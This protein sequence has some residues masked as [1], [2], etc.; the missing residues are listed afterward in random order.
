MGFRRV[1]RNENGM[2]V[3]RINDTGR[4]TSTISYGMGGVSVDPIMYGGFR[5]PELPPEPVDPP[6]VD[7]IAYG[8][9]EGPVPATAPSLT[10]GYIGDPSE[11]EDLIRTAGPY[12]APTPE[13]TQMTTGSNVDNQLI[14]PGVSMVKAIDQPEDGDGQPDP[15]E[16]GESAYWTDSTTGISYQFKKERVDRKWRPDTDKI[17][18]D[19]EEGQQAYDNRKP[20]FL[21]LGTYTAKERIALEKELEAGESSYSIRFSDLEKIK[22]QISDLYNPGGRSFNKSD[23]HKWLYGGYTFGPTGSPEEAI[24]IILDNMPGVLS[25]FDKNNK[26]DLEKWLTAKNNAVGILATLVE[27]TPGHSYSHSISKEQILS[28]L[29]AGQSDDPW[30][31]LD[32]TYKLSPFWTERGVSTSVPGTDYAEDARSDSDFT[33]GSYSSVPWSPIY[34]DFLNDK[35]GAAGSPA[36]FKYHSDQG[37]SNDPLQR[38]AYTQFLTQATED[39]PWGGKLE[40][41]HVIGKEPQ[42]GIVFGPQSNIYDQNR[43]NNFLQT[44]VPLTGDSLTGRIGEIIDVVK[45]VD[46]DYPGGTWDRYDPV[47][48]DQDYSSEQL[49]AYRWRHSFFEGPGSVVNQ[50]ALAALPIMQ[51]THP[52]LRNETS[53]ILH[54]LHNDWLTTPDKDP[55]VGWLQYVHENDYFGM[56]PKDKEQAVDTTIGGAQWGK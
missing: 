40:G 53:K 15:T 7:P 8:Q 43:Y 14:Q 24:A 51:N 38:T 13:P 28:Q 21:G 44:Y 26:D 19:T 39:D 20:S 25:G 49:Q 34:Q 32:K 48:V 54:R 29:N 3:D 31:I 6:P 18:F 55:T 33:A 50:K 22:L 36:V 5:E 42:G 35:F 41:G 2:F 23:F 27:Y 1:S 45:E 52:T 11:V 16:Y 4:V 30:G 17:I 46:S 37:L 47:G 10:G 9:K 56:I 12:Q